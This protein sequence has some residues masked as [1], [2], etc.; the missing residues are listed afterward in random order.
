M[1]RPR[2]IELPDP[3]EG[4]GTITGISFQKK[5]TNRCS[6]HIN[7]RFAFGL[8]ADLVMDAGLA[9]GHR[10][11]E[12]TCRKLIAR[13]LF[14]K[15][16]KRAFDLLAH[17]PRTRFELDSRLRMLSPVESVVP[18]VRDRVDA[19]GYLDDAAFARQFIAGRMSAGKSGP[20]RIRMELRHKGVNPALIETALQESIQPE[21]LARNLDRL[22]EKARRR[23][24]RISE[25]YER[26]QKITA[27]LRRRGYA[28]DA[29]RDALERNPPG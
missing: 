20:D 21:D 1:R 5:D 13:D 10:I 22:V 6:V 8:H 23:Y 28:F 19:L 4:G 7:G 25:G 2:I 16:L 26:R 11:D 29:I 17:R 24:A 27:W 9:K 3:P 14:H 18:R 12:E 15:L